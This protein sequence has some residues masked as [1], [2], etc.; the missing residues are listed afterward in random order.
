MNWCS[1]NTGR[2]KIGRKLQIE[3]SNIRWPRQN[4]IDSILKDA[5]LRPRQRKDDIP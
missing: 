1:Q 5:Q 3:T 4:N 2:C